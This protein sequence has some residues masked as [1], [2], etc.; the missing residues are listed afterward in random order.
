MNRSFTRT[1]ITRSRPRAFG[2]AVVIAAATL[3]GCSSDGTRVA[4]ETVATTPS[5]PTPTTT[6]A[7]STSVAL[8]TTV[9]AASPTLLD[10][11]PQI[12]K[13]LAGSLEP[14]FYSSFSDTLAAALPSGASIGVRV[15]GQPDLLVSA[16]TEALAPDVP[17]SATAPFLVG[18]ISV[19]VLYT[20]FDMVVDD[21]TVDPSD[22]LA[23]WLPTYPNG[24]R[25][26]AQMLRDGS[27]GGHGMA[28]IDNWLELVSSDWSRNWTPA[29]VLAEAATR[30]PGAIGDAGSDSTAVVALR[31]VMEQATGETLDQLVRE[32]L[33]QPLGLADTG[34]FD[35]D[36]PPAG[37]SHGV[38][39]LGGEAHTS[40]DF[41][42]NS[43]TS[44][45]LNVVSTLSDQLTLAE[46]IASGGLADFE[47][48]PT[49][50]KFPSAR[51][52]SD[53]D[54]DRYIG[55]GFPLNL[56]CPCSDV[57]DG[58]TGTAVGRRANAPGTLTHWYYFPDTGIT[59]VLHMNSNESSTPQ[60]VMELVYGI[61]EL[62]SGQDTPA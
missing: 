24:D 50:D 44:M 25:I 16:G 40:A 20:L 5:T 53:D 21:G 11:E 7:P 6:S 27:Y 18:D 32:R 58:H 35:A 38:F 39:N 59:I 4:D 29:E 62:V 55:D 1:R 17:F 10:V 13:A 3:A 31:Y 30:P 19:N 12:Q 61:H 60:E 45:F 49:P 22:T 9:A 47:R 23:M 34:V 43:Y 26:T 46:A 33:A 36:Q 28:A 48:R 54:G 37:L 8:L 56:H 52:Q 14:G 41:P 15:P 51:L 57:G 2:C 42:L